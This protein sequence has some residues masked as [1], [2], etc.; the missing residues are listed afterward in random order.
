MS[1]D[2]IDTEK[3]SNLI[4]LEENV[5]HNVDPLVRC[6][7]IYELFPA[8]PQSRHIKTSNLSSIYSI[9]KLIEYILERLEICIC[10]DCGSAGNSLYIQ[11][12]LTSG[13]TL[14]SKAREARKAMGDSEKAIDENFFGYYSTHDPIPIFPID[15]VEGQTLILKISGDI[16]N[17]LHMEKFDNSI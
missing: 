3:S 12:H 1:I 8:D 14:C 13:S 17:M 16:L 4:K 9:I 10:R 15:F 2:T 6:D 11:S 5:G 7:F